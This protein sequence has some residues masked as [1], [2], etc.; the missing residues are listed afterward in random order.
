MQELCLIIPTYNHFD[1][2][3]RCIQSFYE[4]EPDLDATVCVIDDCS[5]ENVY[6][7]K[8]SN[9]VTIHRFDTRGGLTRSWNYGLALAKDK[10]E[11]T[12]CTNNDI[13]FTACWY[14]PLKEALETLDLVGP[15][16]N[17]PG[18]CKW[19]NINK[20]FHL[21]TLN[22]NR[23]MLDWIGRQCS[24]NEIEYIVSEINGFFMMAKTETWWKNSFDTVHV[25]NPANHMTENERELQRRW[26]ARK[27]RVG[28]TPRSFI[29]HYRS[30]SRPEA[31]AMDE[32]RGAYRHNVGVIK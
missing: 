32:S 10:Y 1:Y 18:H 14:E 3:D 28:F 2:A 21:Y 4:T 15:V 9:K 30:V 6:D 22:D 27:L 8:F 26:K 31:L 16:T 5:E 19:Q 23:H 24:F 7:Y 25:F 29:F 20:F 11:Y 12:I 13:L 17:T